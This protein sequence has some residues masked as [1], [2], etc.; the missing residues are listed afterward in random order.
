MKII[1]FSSWIGDKCIAQILQIGRWHL[2]M[3]R[4]TFKI[5]KENEVDILNLCNSAFFNC[6]HKA[7]KI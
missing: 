7:F 4:E 3:I 5:F 1:V 2:W 6:L